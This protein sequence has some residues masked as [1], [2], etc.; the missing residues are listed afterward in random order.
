V[1]VVF[2]TCH[3]DLGQCQKLIDWCSEIDTYPNHQALIVASTLITNEQ[4]SS[5]VASA[6]KSFS[7]VTAIKQKIA[8]EGGWPISPN[9]MFQL[10]AQWV[11]DVGRREWLWL[12]PDAIPLRAGWLDTLQSEY[13]AGGK[14]FMGTV[15]EWVSAVRKLP[16]LT[17]TAIYPPDLAR[18]NPYV[19]NTS[20][21]PFDCT[22]PDIT[23]KHAHQTRLIQHVWGDRETNVAPTFPDPTSL[24]V[25]DPTSVVWHRCKDGSLIERL[26]EIREK[27]VAG[28]STA[29]KPAHITM[30][31][32]IRHKVNAFFNGA[33]RFSHAGNLGDVVYALQ[34]IKTFGG[35]D[36]IISPQ[37]RGTPP[38]MVPISK[39]QFEMALPLLKQQKYLRNVTWSEAYPTGTHDLNHFRTFWV[40]RILKQREG[41]DTLAKAHH[42]ELGV[43]DK[44]NHQDT[45]LDVAD[46]INTGKI[47]IHRS[48]RYNADNFPWA[49]LISERGKDLLFVGMQSEHEKFQR[50]FRCEVSFYKVREFAELAR[51]ICGAKACV[52]NQ[53]FP[54]SIALGLGQTVIAEACPRSPDCRYDRPNVTD[55]LL[56]RP[57]KL[58]FLS[59]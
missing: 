49:R 3:K 20:T 21:I 54:L 33:N 24:S 2:P 59:L 53:S 8:E 7:N 1:I 41:L 22:R 14:P 46:P 10:A 42:Y 32:T 43:L 16:H 50:D 15:F 47:V 58:D 6:Q 17:G 13:L 31:S 5:L 23:L 40:D 44:F 55:Q 26:R 48:P 36:L 37:Q 35:G 4:I 11:Q 34:A 25:I 18:L 29:A 12:E 52:M 39:S 57:E 45:W 56:T 9:R 27:A 30:A 19:L 38:C 51:L 28:V